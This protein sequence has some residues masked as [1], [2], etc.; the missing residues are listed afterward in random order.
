MY[1]LVSRLGALFSLDQ[2]LIFQQ[3]LTGDL[4]FP[5]QAFVLCSIPKRTLVEVF[6][7]RDPSWTCRINEGVAGLASACWSPDSRHVLTMADFQLHLTVWSLVD[8]SQMRITNPK[9][10]AS[11]SIFTSDGSF[12][13]I[14]Q[15]RECKDRVAI[16]HTA[17]WESVHFTPHL[18]F[19]IAPLR[20]VQ[21]RLF[22][23]LRK[24]RSLLLFAQICVQVM[25]ACSPFG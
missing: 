23:K 12:A 22:L 11:P 3:L 2:T 4:D 20:F 16:Y 17:K 15:R 5:I 19:E 25:M 8:R 24:V 6:S 13:A 9:L 21:Y 14:V 18:R 10:P 7:V 1:R